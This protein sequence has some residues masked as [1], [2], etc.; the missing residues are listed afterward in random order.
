MAVQERLLF[1]M[2]PFRGVA[3][4]LRCKCAPRH[5][6]A[7]SCFDR[8]SLRMKW[9]CANML[10]N[11][12]A[13][14]K[15]RSDEI[16]AKKSPSAEAEIALV[17]GTRLSQSRRKHRRWPLL[18]HISRPPADLSDTHSAYIFR[19]SALQSR[20]LTKDLKV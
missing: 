9:I 4:Y 17:R 1:E 2:E 15:S 8:S 7:L 10:V 5:Q 11:A 18:H 16:D 12:S 3:F 20:G 6:T 19:A 14:E 13:A